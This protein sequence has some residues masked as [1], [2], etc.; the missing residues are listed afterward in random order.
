MAGE[1]SRFK[2]EGYTVPKP[3]LKID[4]KY[5]FEKAL[6]SLKEIV[7][8]YVDVNYTFIVRQ[9]HINNNN[10][11]ILLKNKIKNC[12][13]I[14]VKETTRGAAETCMLAEKYIQDDENVIILDCDLFARSYS[15]ENSIKNFRGDGAVLSFDSNSNK[16]SYA[17]TDEHNRVIKTAEKNPISNNA[18]AGVYFFKTGYLFKKYA[19]RLIEENDVKN[20][21]EYYISLIYNKMIEDTLSITLFK[22]DELKSFGTPEEYL[23]N[24]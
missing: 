8:Q 23:K 3:L 22:L 19:K 14:S 20:I 4:G 18:L 24:D 17:L 6:D 10:I 15:F 11:N 7:K 1:G 5:F 12:N 9:E 13:I 21:K 2:K 16:Y